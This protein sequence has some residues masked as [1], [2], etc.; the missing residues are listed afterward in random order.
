MKVHCDEGIANHIG[1]EPCAVVCKGGGEASVGDSIGQPLSP[2]T[3]YLWDADALPIVEGNTSGAPS[4]ALGS[5][6]NKDSLAG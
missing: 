4:R 6:P 1:P 5:V 2:E 3:T